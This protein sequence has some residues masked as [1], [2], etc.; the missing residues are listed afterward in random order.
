MLRVERF[1]HN[2]MK[3]KAYVILKQHNKKENS[4]TKT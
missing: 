3:I 2:K 1:V 4:K